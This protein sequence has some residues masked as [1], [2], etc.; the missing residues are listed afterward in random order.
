MIKLFLLLKI[1]NRFTERKKTRLK[2]ASESISDIPSLLDK[3][4]KEEAPASFPTIYTIVSTLK[5]NEKLI[6]LSGENI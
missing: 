1:Q 2:R 6:F 5:F 4:K 3:K